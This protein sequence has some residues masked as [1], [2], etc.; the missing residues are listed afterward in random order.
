MA[1]IVSQIGV[2]VVNRVLLSDWSVNWPQVKRHN[3]T[4]KPVASWKTLR[5]TLFNYLK[6]GLLVLKYSP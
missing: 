1:S 4:Q 6:L 3:H 5:G 2:D